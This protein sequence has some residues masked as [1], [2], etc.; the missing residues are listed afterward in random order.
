M[1]EEISSSDKAGF[2]EYAF[3]IGSKYVRVY[4]NSKQINKQTIQRRV[5]MLSTRQ[6]NGQ[7]NQKKTRF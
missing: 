4:T 7:C 3:Q 2:T 5:Q 6:F 1:L